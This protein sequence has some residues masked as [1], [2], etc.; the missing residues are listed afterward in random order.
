MET[1]PLRWPFVGGNQLQPV[2]SF[3][4]DMALHNLI[5]FSDE[6]AVE[7]IVEL[8]VFWDHMIHM[9]RHGNVW[10]SI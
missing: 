8:S 9:W 10:L 4:K 1:L 2:V 7:Q 3:Q 6:Q 5:C